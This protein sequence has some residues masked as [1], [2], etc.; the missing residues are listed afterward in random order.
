MKTHHCPRSNWTGPESELRKGICP[1]CA[2]TT[3]YEDCSVRPMTDKPITFTDEHGNEWTLQAEQSER[4]PG[5]CL[6]RAATPDDLAR[7]GYTPSAENTDV[8]RLC[9]EAAKRTR[10]LDALRAIEQHVRTGRCLHSSPT[11]GPT[12]ETCALLAAVEEARK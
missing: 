3:L 4:A 1:K 11:P 5:G 6:I 2:E 8:Q 7:A 9:L 12:C 10:E